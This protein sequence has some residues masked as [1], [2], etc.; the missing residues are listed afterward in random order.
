MQGKTLVKPSD[1]LDLT[2]EVRTPGED[3]AKIMS[4]NRNVGIIINTC[5]CFLFVHKELKEEITR[6]LT[7]NNP[8]APQNV[9]RYSFKVKFYC[10]STMF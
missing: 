6:V 7:A 9:V 4:H 2:E 10:A 8:N 5:F 3:P 1:Q